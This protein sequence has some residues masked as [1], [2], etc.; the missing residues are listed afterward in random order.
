MLKLSDAAKEA[1]AGEIGLPYEQIVRQPVCQTLVYI[2]NRQRRVI[3]V[4]EP[5]PRILYSSEPLLR[6]L[7]KSL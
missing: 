2:G 1:I 3:G 7:V 5:N 6:R 4:G